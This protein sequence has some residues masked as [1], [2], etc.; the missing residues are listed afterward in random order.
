MA[1]YLDPKADLTFK[2]VFGEHMA[3]AAFAS[4]S[5]G[6]GESTRRGGR[7]GCSRR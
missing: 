1:K 7:F 4:L 2:K 3:E 5:F 6:G